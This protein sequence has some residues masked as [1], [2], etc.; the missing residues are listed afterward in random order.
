MS[1]RDVVMYLIFVLMLDLG[2]AYAMQVNSFLIGIISSIIFGAMTLYI[3]FRPFIPNTILE[4][5][6]KGIKT[7]YT[8]REY[9]PWDDI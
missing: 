4:I 1:R 2:C 5:N 3:I 8:K 7:K 6:T 9:I